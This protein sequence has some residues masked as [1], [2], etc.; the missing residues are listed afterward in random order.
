MS[1]QER[2]V[3][4]FFDSI[5]ELKQLF[6]EAA[7]RN[8]DHSE[9][10]NYLVGYLDAL[11]CIPEDMA[12]RTE[13]HDVFARQQLARLLQHAEKLGILSA[14]LKEMNKIITKNIKP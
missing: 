13:V 3:N 2:K 4:A 10:L 14:E 11:R 1:T 8:P 9:M 6:T 7:K 12:Q 5:P